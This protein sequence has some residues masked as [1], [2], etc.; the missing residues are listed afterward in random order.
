MQY[1]VRTRSPR[2]LALAL[3][4]T[5]AAAS[6]AW[7]QTQ[8]PEVEPNS[9]C[10]AAQDLTQTPL[11]LAAN[12]SLQTPP[13]S[14][15]VDF[16]RLAAAP[17]DFV[18]IDADGWSVYPLTLESPLLGVFDSSCNLI[19][20]SDF[21]EPYVYVEVPADGILVAGVTSGWDWDFSGDGPGSGTYRLLAQREPLARGISGR[22]VSSRT[23]Q[24]ISSVNAHLYRCTDW[25]Q[26]VGSTMTDETGAF[27]FE[28]GAFY[29]EGP[30]LAGTYQL[31][32]YRYPLYELYE[33]EPFPL[34][35][36]QDLDL[37]SIALTPLPYVGSIRGRVTD[38][39]TGVPLS[40]SSEP[41]ARV[42]IQTCQGPE[43][44]GSCW[45]RADVPV[46]ADG[47]FLFTAQPDA[48]GLPPG[49]FRVWASAE[50][51]KAGQ[52]EAFYLGDGQN[53]DAGDVAIDSL[54]V[55]LY[56]DQGCGEIPS[57]GGTCNA[58]VRV[59]NGLSTRLH[60][61]AWSVIQANRNDFGSSNVTTFQAGGTQ[62]LN[63][64]PKATFRM[65][66]TFSVPGGVQDGTTI[67]GQTVVAPQNNPFESFGSRYLFCLQKG[68]TGFAAVPEAQKHEAVQKLL[69]RTV[70]NRP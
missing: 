52:S 50:Q 7:A 67:C 31:G 42:S 59:V 32:L 16:Y 9:A 43:D 54:P 26:P 37:G 60:A 56:L 25:C 1:S 34:A 33:S 17:G 46:E 24:P 69:G 65:P 36:G 38:R 15:D 53:H 40:G 11:P 21:Y 61:Q 10:L 49:W 5:L 27:R 6:G 63:L 44:P 55:R 64:A 48:G 66:L 57:S 8:V 58:T 18:R 22:V 19:A 39:V 35:E 28:T 23:G 47:T 13:S 20:S 14:P 68:V 70:P 62:Q 45:Y 4:L 2:V 51:Y 12:G 29:L 30:L 41:V 3:G